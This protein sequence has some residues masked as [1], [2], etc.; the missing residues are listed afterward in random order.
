MLTPEIQ[1]KLSTGCKKPA[2]LIPDGDVVYIT[3]GWWLLVLTGADQHLDDEVLQAVRSCDTR[4][5]EY[6]N[7]LVINAR[8]VD[9]DEGKFTSHSGR[10]A[11][12][13]VVHSYEYGWKPENVRQLID[14][15]APSI[16]GEGVSLSKMFADGQAYPLYGKAA[17]HLAKRATIESYV[18]RFGD[19]V[20]PVGGKLFQAFYEMGFS[21]TCPQ[22]AYSTRRGHGPALGLYLEDVEP[23]VFGF[24]MPRTGSGI[25]MTDDGRPL[26]ADPAIISWITAEEALEEIL[27]KHHYRPGRDLYGAYAQGSLLNRSVDVLRWKG[28]TDAEIEELYED[29]RE[30]AYEAQ[31]EA[32]LQQLTASSTRATGVAP[33]A[34]YSAWQTCPTQSAGG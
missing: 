17:D 8:V 29:G 18:F 15:Y 32:L 33:R 28:L 2:V 31:H 21:I 26:Q 13:I 24:L 14:A 25:K 22:E 30:A 3:N 23:D 11:Q 16:Y 34:P 12:S 20:L 10:K 27:Q 19:K 4:R 5:N 1:A 9:F 6:V 7:W